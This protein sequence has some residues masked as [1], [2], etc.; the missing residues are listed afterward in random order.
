VI[1]TV[2]FSHAAFGGMP[3]G[4]ADVAIVSTDQP[5]GPSAKPKNIAVVEPGC[6]IQIV[7]HGNRP[8][9]NVKGMWAWLNF[10]G[11]NIV[12]AN[13]YMTDRLVTK[14]GDSGAVALTEKDEVVGHVVGGTSQGGS[15]IQEIDYQLAVIRAQFP[16]AQI[17]L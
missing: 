7:L 9:A 17:T 10:P 1:G 2:V 13:T 15:Y 8:Q 16:F 3:R 11:T 14:Q 4:E 5:T 12:L 6:T